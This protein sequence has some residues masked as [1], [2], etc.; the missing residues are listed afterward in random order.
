MY[1][2]LPTAAEVAQQR[3]LAAAPDGQALLVG[4]G[5]G[6]DRLTTITGFT[7]GTADGCLAP[8]MQTA[9]TSR[10]EPAASTTSPRR[11]RSSWPTMTHSTAT[12]RNHR[13]SAQR[14]PR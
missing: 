14:P 9:L 11:A 13:S 10:P 2:E 8:E 3:G 4:D 5:I 1:S 6:L 12:A 7:L